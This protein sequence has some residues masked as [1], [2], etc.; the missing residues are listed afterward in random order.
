VLK[1]AALVALTFAVGIGIGAVLAV[2]T[3]PGQQP[4]AAA[5]SSPTPPVTMTPSP[6]GTPEPASST[7]APT[8]QQETPSPTASETPTVQSTRTASETPTTA[9]ATGSSPPTV[10]PTGA[11]A[12]PEAI[13]AFIEGLGAAI[14][15]GRGRVMF[16]NLHPEVLARYG[17]QACQSYTAGSSIPGLVLT[18]IDSSGPAPWDW[19]L[20]DLTTNIPDAW[21]VTVRWQQPG[22]DENREVHIAPADGTWRWFTDCGEPLD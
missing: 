2:M 3:K 7:P 4:V 19:V 18:Y 16:D 21:N 20:D 22:T 8:A 10:T 6:S 1:L 14:A 12:D 11:T 5:T 9:P 17:Q 13:P 15:D